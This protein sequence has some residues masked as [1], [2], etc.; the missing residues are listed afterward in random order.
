MP[1]HDPHEVSHGDIRCD[2][3]GTIILSEVEKEAKSEIQ[4][5]IS[6]H[7]KE[8]GHKNYSF[9]GRTKIGA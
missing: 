7:A 6:V 3:C 1:E 9:Y 5:A 8:T 4:R 2:D